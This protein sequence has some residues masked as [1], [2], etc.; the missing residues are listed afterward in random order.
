MI[1][2]RPRAPRARRVYRQTVQPRTAGQQHGWPRRILRAAQ[3][4]EAFA[5]CMGQRRFSSRPRPLPWSRHCRQ[6]PARTPGR[7]GPSSQGARNAHHH[8]CRSEFLGYPDYRM[9][10]NLR[11]KHWFQFA[12]R[13]VKGTKP[14]THVARSRCTRPSVLPPRKQGRLV[15]GDFDCLPKIQGEFVE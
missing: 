13:D 14:D 8:T 1:L 10:P 4:G 15:L 6:W 3:R 2:A 7:C 9:E 11:W 5:A 12:C